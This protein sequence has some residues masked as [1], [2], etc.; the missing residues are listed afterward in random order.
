MNSRCAVIIEDE[1]II[2]KHIQILLSEIGFNRI[3]N[4]TSA[5]AY[6]S[7]PERYK[8]DIIILDY[9]LKGLL[10][11]TDMVSIIGNMNTPI[12]FI[13]GKIENAFLDSGLF[14]SPY[15]FISKPFNDDELITAVNRL[16]ALHR[17]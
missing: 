5:E 10:T 12:I 1:A 6:L 11:G 17:T 9:A 14:S 4:Y 13:S 3:S 16:M 2:A 8:P 7:Q 15:I